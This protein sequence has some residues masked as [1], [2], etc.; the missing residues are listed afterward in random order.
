MLNWCQTVFC[1]PQLPM[2]N[3]Q[4]A[5]TY[6]VYTQSRKCLAFRQHSILVRITFQKALS[7]TAIHYVLFAMQ[8]ESI[9]LLSWSRVV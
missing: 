6:H 7:C 2:L 5:I 9:L 1:L 3:V 4:R 8:L